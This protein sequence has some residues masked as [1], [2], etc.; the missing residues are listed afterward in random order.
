MPVLK[1][2]WMNSGRLKSMELMKFSRQDNDHDNYLRNNYLAPYSV[3]LDVTTYW[4]LDWHRGALVDVFG[5][6]F[7]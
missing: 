2:L 6:G 5:G 1:Y 7:C 4:T 3:Q